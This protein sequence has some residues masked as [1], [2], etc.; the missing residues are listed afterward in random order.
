MADGLSVFKT[1]GNQLFVITL[2]C[3]EIRKKNTSSVTL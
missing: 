3:I 1:R 2:D